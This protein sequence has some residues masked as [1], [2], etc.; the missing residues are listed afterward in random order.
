MGLCAGGAENEG[1]TWQPYTDSLVQA[2]LM[3]LPWGGP[4]L[5]GGGSGESDL[6]PVQ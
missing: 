2:A 3:A 6:W 4:E 1:R 5:L